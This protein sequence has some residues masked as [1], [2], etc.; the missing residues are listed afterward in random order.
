MS[1]TA[2]NQQMQK[3][4]SPSLQTT[5]NVAVRHDLPRP[6]PKEHIGE[7]KCGQR[8]ATPLTWPTHYKTTWSNKAIGMLRM[9]FEIWQISQR[10]RKYLRCDRS[11]SLKKADCGRYSF[12]QICIHLFGLSILPLLNKL[13]VENILIQY[14]NSI[15][16]A[17]DQHKPHACTHSKCGHRFDGDFTRHQIGS[18]MLCFSVFFKSFTDTLPQCTI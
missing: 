3:Q 8:F 16:T 10:H 2:L 6:R 9:C 1:I 15:L 4:R 14:L 18:A 5:P 17:K 12:Y 7:D 11:S 13:T